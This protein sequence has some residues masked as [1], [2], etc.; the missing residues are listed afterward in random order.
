MESSC[1]ASNLRLPFH[2]DYRK[3]TP[4]AYTNGQTPDKKILTSPSPKLD[5]VVDAWM[6]EQTDKHDFR[7]P[8]HCLK[9][10]V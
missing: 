4:M 8:P 7:S 2:C 5:K 3:D 10:A 9:Q 1:F 6:Y